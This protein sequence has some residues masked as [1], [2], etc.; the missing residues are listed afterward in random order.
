MAVLNSLRLWLYRVY[1]KC[2]HQSEYK[3]YDSF[4]PRGRKGWVEIKSCA[5]AYSAGGASGKAAGRF[6]SPRAGQR[7]LWAQRF[8]ARVLLS[9]EADSRFQRFPLIINQESANLKPSCSL[10]RNCL[11]FS[12]PWKK[13]IRLKMRECNLCVGIYQLCLSLPMDGFREKLTQTWPWNLRP[14]K[15][16]WKAPLKQSCFSG[17]AEFPELAARSSDEMRGNARAPWQSTTL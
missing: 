15:Q 5:L 4:C 8:F 12:D 7:P 2:I 13:M 1:L 9:P 3:L 14:R 6:G 10:E 17:E 16:T 11:H